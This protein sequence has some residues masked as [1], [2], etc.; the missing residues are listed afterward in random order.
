MR[1]RHSF[2]ALI[3]NFRPGWFDSVK[4]AVAA[5]LLSSGNS[6]KG[7]RYAS[8]NHWTKLVR[9]RLERVRCVLASPLGCA[10]FGELDARL[11]VED[12]AAAP[13]GEG[14]RLWPSGMAAVA[15]A[16]WWSAKTCQRSVELAIIVPEALIQER[17]AFGPRRCDGPG[18]LRAQEMPHWSAGRGQWL[19][20]AMPALSENPVEKLTRLIGKQEWRPLAV[21][22]AHEKAA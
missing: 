7:M 15:S 19:R 2:S 22:L 11:L 14:I 17:R 10:M 20:Q 9:L 12:I 18:F 8:R 13:A 4:A 5:E 1:S 6:V 3:A 21:A 16:G